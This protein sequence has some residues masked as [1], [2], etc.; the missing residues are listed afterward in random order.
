MI[1]EHHHFIEM[2]VGFL[3]VGNRAVAE[4]QRYPPFAP[5]HTCDAPNVEHE[6]G[7]DWQSRPPLR[8]VWRWFASH[9]TSRSPDHRNPLNTA[10]AI[11]QAL[12][13]GSG[14]ADA[15]VAANGGR[16]PACAKQAQLARMQGKEEG[17]IELTPEQHP[18]LT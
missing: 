17:M 9:G 12:R 6:T 11:C 13:P 10:V 7:R 4:G 5:L 16:T 3:E 15:A 1:H 18:L 8:I 14:P 2:G